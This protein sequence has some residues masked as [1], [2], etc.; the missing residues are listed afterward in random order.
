MNFRR[1]YIPGGAV[2]ITQVVQDREPIF[3]DPQAMLL[4]RETLRNVKVLH[5][6]T[7]LGYVFLPD[8]F[9]I[10]LQPTGD[11]NFS[12][13]MHSLKPNFT[14]EY[15]K[16]LGLLPSQAMIFW[17][18]R[19]WDHVIRDDR[20]FENHLHYIHNNPVKHGYVADARDWKDSSYI[21]WEKRGL[22]PL[23]VAWEEP[24]NEW[25]E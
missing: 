17:Q 12:D 10:I 18:K 24:E 8:H 5:P 22:Y 6:F 11:S 16:R 13:I 7:M 19:F 20:D 4:L 3:R 2:F 15:K 23:P 14:K 21:E 9:H 25:G 1:H